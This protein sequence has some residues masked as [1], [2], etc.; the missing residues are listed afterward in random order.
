ML[1]DDD[2]LAALAAQRFRREF[3]NAHDIEAAIERGRTWW[4]WEG[5]RAAT[6]FILTP[7]FGPLTPWTIG[8]GTIAGTLFTRITRSVFGWVLHRFKGDRWF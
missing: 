1:H 7:I 3:Q 5:V 2:D 8:L 6:T 4:L